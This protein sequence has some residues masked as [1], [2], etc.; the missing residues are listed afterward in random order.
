ME[1]LSVNSRVIKEKTLS[2][3][4]SVLCL[5]E[6]TDQDKGV[7]LILSRKGLKSSTVFAGKV[8]SLISRDNYAKYFEIIHSQENF[9]DLSERIRKSIVDTLKA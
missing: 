3:G 8:A 9:Y 2:D 6:S 4:V 1:K 7:R 5:L